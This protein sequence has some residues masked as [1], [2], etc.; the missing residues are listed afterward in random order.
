MAEPNS[1]RESERRLSNWH[2]PQSFADEERRETDEQHHLT[3]FADFK[4]LEELR[5]LQAGERACLAYIERNGSSKG[6]AIEYLRSSVDAR[7]IE[8]R[9]LQAND[10]SFDENAPLGIGGEVLRS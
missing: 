6:R 7:E 1:I 3:R 10:R 2:A 8:I 5:E 9:N 4:A